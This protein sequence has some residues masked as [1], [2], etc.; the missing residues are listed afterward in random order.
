MRMKPLTVALVVCALASVPLLEGENSWASDEIFAPAPVDSAICRSP[1]GGPPLLRQLLLAQAATQ[2]HRHPQPKTETRPFAPGPEAKPGPASTSGHP[3]LYPDL[4]TLSMRITTKSPLAQQYFDQGLRLSFAFNHAEARRAFQA[5]QDLD[6]DCAMCYWGEALVLG[7]NIN[8]PM[9]PAAVI[10]AITAT[11]HAQDLAPK[12]S[13][14]EQALIAALVRRYSDD[15]LAVRP[16]LDAQYA[17]G[18]AEVARRF[19][20]DDNIQTLYAESIMDLSPW[21]YWEIGGAVPKG[22]AGEAV[23]ALERVLQRN[24]QHP[25]AVH[26]YIHAVEASNKPER[27]LPYA[28]RLGKLMPGAGHIVHMPAHIYFRVGRYFDALQTNIDAVAADERYFAQSPSDPF[29]RNAYYPHNLHFLMASAMMGGD[30]KTALD[31]AA[32]LSEAIDPDAMRQAAALQPVKAAPYFAHVQFSNPQTILALPDPG[33]E[34]PL[35]KGM[36]HYARAVAYAAD[37]EITQADAEIDALLE[38]EDKADFK[39]LNDWAVPG[40]EIIRTARFVAEG[41][42][43]TARG[44]LDAAAKAFQEAIE[45]QDSLAYMEPPYWYY[46]VRQSL[47]AVLLRAGQVAEAEKAFRESLVKTPNNGWALYGL[48]QVYRQNGDRKAARETERVLKRTWFGDQ[49]TLDLAR[50]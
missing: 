45:I 10:P 29:Y 20:E 36:W 3:P 26:F 17:N 18:M 12:A 24:M 1:N 19:P 42:V 2:P 50:L 35:I 49:A 38:I 31:A 22:R 21:D 41:R 25:G 16:A 48:Q 30:R 32:K 23:S 27:A 39:P 14:K 28:R 33:G 15:P 37:K 6:P 40:R 13:A 9:M 47:G 43:A 7:P 44:D 4:G 46:P 34:F 5:A 8:A 11:Q